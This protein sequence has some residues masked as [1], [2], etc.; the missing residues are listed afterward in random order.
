VNEIAFDIWQTASMFL[1]VLM[2]AQLKALELGTV[3]M[4]CFGNGKHETIQ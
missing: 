2:N 3:A 1:P 4:I